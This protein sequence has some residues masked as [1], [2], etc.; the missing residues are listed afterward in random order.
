[1]PPSRSRSAQPASGP[2]TSP[3]HPGRDGRWEPGSHGRRPGGGAHTPA[4]GTSASPAIPP[5]SPTELRS[6]AG[7]PDRDTFPHPRA[8]GAPE[9]PLRGDGKLRGDRPTD[10]VRLAAGRR[11]GRWMESTPHHHPLPPGRHGGGTPRRIL[12]R[13]AEEGRASQARGN[14]RLWRDLLEPHRQLRP[15]SPAARD[16]RQH[17]HRG[18]RGVAQRWGGRDPMQ[19]DGGPGHLSPGRP[20]AGTATGRPG[21]AAGPDPPNA[22]GQD[23]P[24]L[25]GVSTTRIAPLLR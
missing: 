7:P 18:P 4:R 1:M 3:D 9:H 25:E 23:S 2:S 19:E 13:A 14:P 11:A 21:A 8:R 24:A 22:A 20:S 16:G 10:R 5:G 17:R 12:R 15:N 6:A